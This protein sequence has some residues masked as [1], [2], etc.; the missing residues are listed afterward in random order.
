MRNVF[1][2]AVIFWL[3]G[4]SVAFAAPNGTS[5]EEWFATVF[6]GS[7]VGYVRARTELTQLDKKEAVHVVRQS[8]IAVRRQTQSI[9]IEDTLEAWFT[10]EGKPLRYNLV[11]KEGGAIRRGYGQLEGDSFVVR[12]SVGG[13]EN[14]RRYKLEPGLRLASSLEWLH[15]KKLKAGLVVKGHVIVETEGDMQPFSI[16]IEDKLKDPQKKIYLVNET[17]GPIKSRTQVQEGKGVL[18]SEV[19]AARMELVRTTPEDAV[20]LDESVDIFGAALFPVKV[21][22]P[23]SEELQGLSLLFSTDRDQ[24]LEIRAFDRQLVSSKGE[25]RIQVKLKAARPPLVNASIPIKTPSLQPYLVST[26]Y[27]DLTDKHLISAAKTAVGNAKDAWTAAQR[28]NGFV[29]R[30]IREK[31][32]AHAFSSATEAYRERSGDCTEHA[33][34]FSAL[35]KIVGIPTKLITGL[36]YVG[37]TKP[38]FGYHE[39]VEVWLGN[40]W[41]PMDPTFD[42][43]TADTTHVKFSEGLSDPPG[44]RDAGLVA[45]GLIGDVGISVLTYTMDGKE[46]RP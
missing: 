17:L 5:S 33:V 45:A 23:R 8:V 32:L 3:V 44:L 15:F 9:R 25:G 24:G 10:P 38:V 6:H 2:A 42:Q 27:E 41:H 1:S 11:R 21:R 18:H 39:W 12:H 7:K 43:V 22:L 30:H 14:T 31:T 19:I 34:L 28:I 35:A 20:R 26:D 36:V 16:H 4:S 46:I 29:N 13:T 40:E 37:G